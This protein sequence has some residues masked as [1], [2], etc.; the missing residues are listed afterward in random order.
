[1]CGSGKKTKRK[2]ETC[3][4]AGGLRCLLTVT[5][6]SAR[7][8][9]LPCGLQDK[10]LADVPLVPGICHAEEVGGR[11]GGG[12]V[13]FLFVG[14]QCC[15]R[16]F[17]FP[18]ALSMDIDRMRLASTRPSAADLQLSAAAAAASSP[19]QTRAKAGGE[20]GLFVSVPKH[21]RRARFT[22]DGQYYLFSADF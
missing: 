22:P 15:C 4:R 5:L 16:F 10:Q 2:L 17:P 6:P 7:R 13:C 12:G 9:R 1:M 21:H 3:E 8:S 18:A 19:Q 14:F 11:L 20:E